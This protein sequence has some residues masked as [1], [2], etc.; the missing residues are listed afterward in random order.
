M[1][2]IKGKCI[3]KMQDELAMR[4]HIT[5]CF[6]VTG[7]LCAAPLCLML[8]FSSFAAVASGRAG[9]EFLTR[10]IVS[11]LDRNLRWERNSYILKIVNGVATITLFKDDPVRRAA[12]EKHLR[13][14][15]GLV[16]MTIVVKPA[17]A[18]KPEAISRWPVFLSK[19]YL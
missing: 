5:P 16:G 17:D 6:K 18:G 14:I 8:L 7:P 4:M 3:K 19:K 10:Y 9:D 13:T 12:A 1:A 2:W 11:L 15:D